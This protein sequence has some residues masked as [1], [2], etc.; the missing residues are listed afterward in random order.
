PTQ[1]TVEL[2][3]LELYE[4]QIDWWW[5]TGS[6]VSP[7]SEGNFELQGMAPGAA[8]TVRISGGGAAQ[9]YY[10][11]DGGVLD[12]MAADWWFG[13]VNV[14]GKNFHVQVGYSIQGNFDLDGGSPPSGADVQLSRWNESNETWDYLTAVYV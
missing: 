10:S 14:T 6:A 2:I 7:D 3:G 8:Y 11:E 12:P 9:M 5:P 1:V 13:D 4:G